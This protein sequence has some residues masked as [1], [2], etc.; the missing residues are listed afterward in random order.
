MVS[1]IYQYKADRAVT[2]IEHSLFPE[3]DTQKHTN[4]INWDLNIKLKL[5]F[6]IQNKHV[7]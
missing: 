7:H 6:V 4:A 3:N 1:A 5:D 2:N